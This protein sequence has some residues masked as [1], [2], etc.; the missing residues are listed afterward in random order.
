MTDTASRTLASR[1]GFFTSDLAGVDPELA[2]AIAHELGRQNE[3]IELIA[4]ENIVS[5]AVLEAQGSVLTN[6]YAEGYP[7]KRYYGGCEYVDVAERLAIDRAKRLFDC[8]YANVQPH[9]GAQANQAVFLALLKPG[10]KFLG[11][12]LACGGHLTHGSPANLSGKWFQPVAYGVREDD[13]RID[14]DEVAAIA[15]RERPQLI[16]AGGSAYSRVID[17]KRFREI[18]DEVGAY[19]MVD[20]AHFAGLVAGGVYPSPLP[21]AHV[22]TTT[23]HKTL[24]G[25][26][27]G[28]ILTNDEELGKKFNSAVFPGLQGGPLMHVIAAK[29]VAF[30]EALKPDFKLYA[31]RVVENAKA[32]ADRLV[33]GG[34]AVVS[35]G[36]DSHLALV[37]LRPMRVTGKAAEAGLERALITCNKNGIPYDPEKPMVTSG[38]RVGSPACTTRGFGPAEFQEVADLIIETLS[39]LAKSNG[40]NSAAEAAVAAKVKALTARFPIYS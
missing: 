1:A 10:D 13:Q 38:I 9:S 19:F 24:R 6:K 21:H 34:L 40:D 35:G 4:S 12:D 20:M 28:M 31:K 14:Y 2:A 16:I 7:G 29:A 27:G 22:V 30:G 11:M 25:P 8:A 37:D 36:T 33:A 32:M 23:T 18:A 39:G 5:R 3:Q 26:R 17:F 15:R